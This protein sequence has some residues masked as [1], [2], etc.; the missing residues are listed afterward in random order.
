MCMFGWSRALP[1]PHPPSAPDSVVTTSASSSL[2]VHTAP[3]PQ[4][5]VHP[6][7]QCSPPPAG[8]RPGLRR[9]P[10]SLRRDPCLAKGHKQALGHHPGCCHRG[11]APPPPPSVTLTDHG[12]PGSRS[13]GF[14]V[15]SACEQ[16]KGVSP[17]SR[18]AVSPGIQEGVSLGIPGGGEPRHP[19]RG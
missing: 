11:G 16:T 15:R 2:S 5:P 19:G 3:G 12:R 9:S 14:Q 10:K 17:T 8:Q 18:E 7:I 1:A 6:E 4:P 13:A